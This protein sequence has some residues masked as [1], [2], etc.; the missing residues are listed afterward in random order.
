MELFTIAKKNLKN[1]FS[2]YSFY[3]I[4]VAFVLMVFFSFISFSMNDIV[5]EKISSD[6]RVETMSKTVAIFVMAFVLFYMSYSNTFFMK[7]RMNELGIYSL[8][9]YRK[10]TML[11]L[12]TFENII[13][14]F[15][16]LFVG[17]IFGAIA[18]KGIV[19]VII[20]IL[21]LQID[22]S[23]VPFINLD[24]VLF[25][26]AFIF[27][28]LF[29]LSLSNWIILRKSSLLTLVR[30]EQKEENKLKINTAFSLL[31]LVLI[32]IGY[33]LA[34]DITRGMQSLWKTIGFSAI[35]LLTMFSVILGTIFFIHSF[36][37]YA[38]QK[39]KKN[40]IWFYKESNIIVIPN[41][42][43]KIRS[44][45][46]TLI[47]LTLLTAGTLAIFSS[48]LLTLYYPVAATERIVPSAIEFPLEDKE[49]A[50]KSL[51]TVQKTVGKERISY[52]E[53]TII[54]VK[55][56]SD[57]LPKEY[58]IKK[59]HGFDLISE[60]DYRELI[61]V[62][63]KNVE[64]NTL[65][66]NESILVK[67][68]PEKE[69]LDKGKIYTLNVTPTTNIDVKVKDTT[70]LN[71]IGFANSVGTLIISDQLYKEIK[72]LE[73]PQKTI[74]SFN[75]KDIRNNKAVY[76]NLA[77]LFKNN[78]Y[79]TSSYQKKDYII[80]QNSSTF[81]LISFVTIIFFIATGSILYFHNLSSMMSNKNEFI[82]LNRMG[83]NKKKIKR[84]IS[85]EIFT[86]FSIPYIIGLAHSIFALLAY[87][88]ALMDD[89]LG[90]SSA[91]ILPILFAVIIFTVV[92]I[93]Y[94][95]LTK[96]A[97]YKIIFNK[98]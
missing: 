12:L 51:Q 48:T 25:T 31:G 76:E 62:Q 93:V 44:K 45:A 21:K 52:T 41:F 65:A 81:L 50:N 39:L 85:K 27:A 89:L 30:M 74:V 5:M 77:P 86:L 82:I 95:L 42:I 14:C 22:T 84:I 66:K 43:F 75:G 38:I 56:N 35:A 57:S 15:A 79:F 88:T 29:V 78:M 98:K 10:S 96:R 18:H 20:K 54:N 23:K 9:G 24:A 59:E 49:V 97:C 8:L 91:F 67:Y 69:H 46:K 26:F 37:P 70:L 58:S 13:I 28:V 71:P 72:T 34:L 36:L 63:D 87:K 3:F 40:K 17:V 47:L 68:R 64:F 33:F 73:L 11:K 7:K 60:S 92:Y 6:G 4:S 32:L 16:A 90:K 61:H 55:S 94:Y 80:Q 19:G 83:Y 53:T 2:F 1:N